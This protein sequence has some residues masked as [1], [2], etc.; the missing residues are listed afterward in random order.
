[1]RL[2][3]FIGDFDFSKKIFKLSSVELVSQL[4]H[5]LRF[6]IGDELILCN[7]K[8]VQARCRIQIIDKKDITVTLQEVLP[9]V[10]QNIRNVTLYCALL[11]RE[12][13]EWVAQKATEVGI[14]KLVP[15]ISDRTVKLTINTNRIQKIMKEASEQC[16]RTVVPELGNSVYFS[17]VLGEMVKEFDIVV[18]CDRVG[19]EFSSFSIK[20]DA[21]IAVCIGPE[22][23]WSEG[24]YAIIKQTP[25]IVCVSLGTLT[26][27]AETAAIIA[28]YLAI[29]N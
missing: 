27:R 15:L 1:M 8:G 17:G 23:G 29:N 22:G 5:V 19:K 9:V 25:K 7:S 11:K 24:E 13:F 18:V 16:G 21:R 14:A 3:R 10:K 4:K 6:T 2:H 28:S 20:K 12:N 26:L